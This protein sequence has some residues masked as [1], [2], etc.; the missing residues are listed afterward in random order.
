MRFNYIKTRYHFINLNY[1]L[2]IVDLKHIQNLIQ[3]ENIYHEQT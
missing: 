3:Y 2:V 1:V